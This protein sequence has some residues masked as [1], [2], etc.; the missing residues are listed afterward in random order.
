MRTILVIAALFGAV[1]SA[2]AQE[3]TGDYYSGDSS[4]YIGHSPYASEDCNYSSDQ[5]FV[6]C[7]P[8]SGI[9]HH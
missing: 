7:V 5:P 6:V 8:R 1:F 9:G 2:Q 4:D 3:D